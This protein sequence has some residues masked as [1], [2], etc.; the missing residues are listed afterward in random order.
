MAKKGPTKRSAKRR[1]RQRGED[2]LDTVERFDLTLEDG[3]VATFSLADEVRINQKS[4][5][6]DPEWIQKEAERAV[7]RY[8]FWAY[9]TE[10]ALATVRTQELATARL[11]AA[12]YEPIRSGF[13]D[14]GEEYIS[15][16]MMQSAISR[17]ESVVEAEEELDG[18]RRQYGILR[19]VRDATEHRCFILRAMLR[20]AVSETWAK[21]GGVQ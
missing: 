7:A 4:Y 8:T 9:Q 2:F 16:N 15:E 14:I 21:S 19:A 12:F 20:N 11:R 1:D 6:A 10:R 17:T 5:P 3:E 13:R 18:L